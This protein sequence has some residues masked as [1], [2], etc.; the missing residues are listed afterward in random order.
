MIG[1]ENEK[2][3]FRAQT[4]S[5]SD[6]MNL[7]ALNL[8]KDDEGYLMLSNDADYYMFDRASRGWINEYDFCVSGNQG[9]RF[10]WGV[11]VGVHDVNYKGYSIY[12]ERLVNAQGSNTGYDGNEDYVDYM[13]KR[14]IEGT[15]IDVKA[16]IIFRPIEDSPFRVGLSVSTPTWYE[17]SSEN[18][19]D[20]NNESEYGPEDSW[21][22]DEKY[23]FRYFTAWKFGAS[24]G[25]TIGNNIALGLSYEISDYSAADNRILSGDYNSSG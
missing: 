15:G 7:N 6:Y 1:Y 10:Y 9:D 13:D 12:T 18:V 14:M 23:D 24:L 20:F 21:F 3:D 25:H 22:S 17:L 5:Q 16:G 19:S 11:T 4:F 8:D 2:S